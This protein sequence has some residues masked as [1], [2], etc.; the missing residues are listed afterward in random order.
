MYSGISKGPFLVS[1]SQIFKKKKK[2]KKRFFF[3]FTALKSQR[4]PISINAAC[5]KIGNRVFSSQNYHF[6]FDKNSII[7]LK[8]RFTSYS[9][10]IHKLK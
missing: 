10:S 2:K 3:P 7:G 5:K 8:M 6:S 9:A 1:R 4:I